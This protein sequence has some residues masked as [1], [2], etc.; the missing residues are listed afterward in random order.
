MYRYLLRSEVMP[1]VNR[2]PGWNVGRS[3]E[4]AISTN[5]L[6]NLYDVR[7]LVRWPLYQKGQ[8]WETGRSRK[9]FRTLVSGELKPFTPPR[10]R[11]S[12]YWFEHNAY[13][14]NALVAGF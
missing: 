14:T 12:F 13:A 2:P 1:F 11:Y 6:N 7:L 9:S 8:N 4:F 10:S 3:N 5:L